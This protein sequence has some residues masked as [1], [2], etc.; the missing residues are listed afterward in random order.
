MTRTD[1]HQ[2]S[3]RLHSIAGSMFLRFS[4]FSI[5]PL[6]RLLQVN[7]LPECR[8]AREAEGKEEVDRQCKEA[9]RLGREMED[10]QRELAGL[11]L[12]VSMWACWQYRLHLSDLGWKVAGAV[13]G[14]R[15][16]GWNMSRSSARRQ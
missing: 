12:A 9:P 3:H 5:L 8:G 4:I 6:P 7:C 14:W 16:R 10:L 11:I 15:L 2:T 1:A 13:A